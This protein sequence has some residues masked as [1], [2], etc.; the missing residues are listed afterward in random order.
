[1]LFGTAKIFYL[2]WPEIADCNE[3]RADQRL[4]LILQKTNTAE[5]YQV[6]LFQVAFCQ[7]KIRL[8]RR[9]P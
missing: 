7:A 5:Q 8:A 9:T 6:L 2:P 3:C 4:A 1:M